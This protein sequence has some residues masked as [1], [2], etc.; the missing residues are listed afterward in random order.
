MTLRLTMCLLLAVNFLAPWANAQ[1]IGGKPLEVRSYW[2]HEWTMKR[3]PA[4]SNTNESSPMT[5][6]WDL[7]ERHDLDTKSL[8]YILELEQGGA[9]FFDP[10]L[11]DYLDQKVLMIAGLHPIEGRPG[12][13]TVRVLRHPSINAFALNN[14]SIVI[15]TG[16]LSFA[17]NEEE[18]LGLLAHEVAHVLLDHN[19]ESATSANSSA[20]FSRFM[21]V[22]GAVAGAAIATSG[23]KRVSLESRRDVAITTGIVAMAIT[24]KVLDVIGAS[25]SRSQEREADLSAKGLLSFLGRDPDAYG[26]FLH[27][28]GM[29]NKLNGVT[30]TSS[31]MDSHPQIEDRLKELTFVPQEGPATPDVEYDR[32]MVDCLT[33]SAA[34]AMQSGQYDYADT[35][36]NRALVSGLATEEAF[37]LKAKSLRMTSN[38][39]QSAQAA[40][41]MLEHASNR[42]VTGIPAASAEKG[43][44]YLRLGEVDKAIVAFQRYI[45]DLSRGGAD[46]WQEELLWAKRM[47]IKCQLRRPGVLAP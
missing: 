41:K 37:F 6:E 13:L 46:E 29:H 25:Y 21:G 1:V 44:L 11:Q 12:S 16:A 45:D 19:L 8:D 39:A 35:L 5:I 23:G 14:G 30:E 26:R 18:L 33:L 40:L 4:M 15:T 9:F 17:R 32:M 20:A 28:L 38:D 47:V 34:L 3:L 43:L 2:K 36:L 7:E 22:V 31:I 10:H 42:M 24:R 27:R